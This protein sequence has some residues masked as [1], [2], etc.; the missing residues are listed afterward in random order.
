M[1]FKTEKEEGRRHALLRDRDIITQNTE[2]LR[3]L[4]GDDATTKLS[5]TA[6]RIVQTVKKWKI[7]LEGDAFL[8]LEAL[9]PKLA[10]E[11][12]EDVRRGEGKGGSNWQLKSGW[13]GFPQDCLV[14]GAV[15]SSGGR[16]STVV[17]RSFLENPTNSYPIDSGGRFCGNLSDY[18]F[19]TPEEVEAFFTEAEAG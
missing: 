15:K 10:A 13:A 5:E 18:Q 9:N 11:V 2:R 4:Y 12:R 19:A 7:S 6:Q 16:R 14:S 17:F 3:K 1:A 8:L